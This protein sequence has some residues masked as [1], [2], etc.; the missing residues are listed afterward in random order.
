MFHPDKDLRYIILEILKEDGKSISAISREL[1]K[2]GYD[3]HRLILTGYL[4]A[5]SDLNVLRE[6]EVPPAKLYVIAKGGEQ[7]IY[8]VVGEKVR[9]LYGEGEKS[10]KLILVALNKLM[11]RAVFSDELS[12]AGVKTYPGH[13][14]S[15][16]ERQD[17]K[18]A[19]IKSGFKVPD[20]VKAY[21]IDAPECEKDY[22]EVVTRLLADL[23]NI[24][25]LV[26]ET[27]QTRLTF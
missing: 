2:R 20:S 25:Y 6:K 7:N 11:H 23:Y 12:K 1:E 22:F 8:E 24:N 26:K 19:L 14:A 13:E 17:A 16:E 27:K 21:T 4:R 9:G 3:Q 10:D 18:Q 15:R 5:M